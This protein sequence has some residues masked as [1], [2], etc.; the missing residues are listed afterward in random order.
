MAESKFTTKMVTFAYGGLSPRTHE[1]IMAELLSCMKHQM[2]VKYQSYTGSALIC[3]ARSSVA[4]TFLLID[5]EDVL[6]FIDHDMWWPAGGMIETARLAYDMN[7]IVGCMYPKRAFGRG[8][9]VSDDKPIQVNIG[10]PS[11]KFEPCTRLATGFLAIP[12][13]CLQTIWD[14]YDID[15]KR[16]REEASKFYALETDGLVSVDWERFCDHEQLGLAKTWAPNKEAEMAGQPNPPLIDFF[17]TVRVHDGAGHHVYLSEDFSFCWRARKAGIKL[18]INT[19]FAPLH[20]GEHAFTLADAEEKNFRKVPNAFDPVAS[21]NPGSASVAEQCGSVLVA[22][23][24][25]STSPASESSVEAGIE[26]DSMRPV[27]GELGPDRVEAVENNQGIVGDPSFAIPSGGGK[28]PGKK[29][30]IKCVPGE[31]LGPRK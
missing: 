22:A 11:A 23:S 3:K 6:F 14:Y 2:P 25:G 27:Q 17:R 9:A 16:W 26:S 28:T 7:A 24:G 15:R 19:H 5:K 4:S 12:R 21:V 10:G 1:A 29:Q 8:Y 20:I 18:G 13:G 30:P 31:I